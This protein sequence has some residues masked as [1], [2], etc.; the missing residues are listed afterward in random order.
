M[1]RQGCRGH[2]IFSYFY[3]PETETSNFITM[4]F[5]KEIK[6]EK[7]KLIAEIEQQKECTF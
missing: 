1:K 6:K 4:P 5:A 7:L 3:I 2:P